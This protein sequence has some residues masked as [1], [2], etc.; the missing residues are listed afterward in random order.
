MRE[1]QARECS[2]RCVN[3]CASDRFLIVNVFMSH[4]FYM[5]DVPVGAFAQEAEGLDQ[6]F[7][8]AMTMWARPSA[9]ICHERIRMP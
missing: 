7:M 2:A 3:Y 5:D 4:L 1:S 8:E 6:M 9:F